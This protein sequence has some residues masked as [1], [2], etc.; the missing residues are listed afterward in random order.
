MASSSRHEAR[1]IVQPRVATDCEALT[2]GSQKVIKEETLT[3]NFCPKN[4][5]IQSLVGESSSN[6]A[7][8]GNRGPN[9]VPEASQMDT[10]KLMKRM[11]SNREASR[12]SRLRKKQ[13][14]EQLERSISFTEMDLAMISPQIAYYQ[15]CNKR[16]EMK[17]NEMR[18]RLVAAELDRAYEDGNM[19]FLPIHIPF[20][21][22][23]TLIANRESA[24]R[25]W[26]RQKEHTAQ[27][28]IKR[29][30]L[31]IKLSNMYQLRTY[32][33]NEHRRLLMENNQLRKSLAAVEFEKDKRLV[34]ENILFRERSAAFEFDKA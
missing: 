26:L 28:E 3:E 14:V 31:Q 29:E 5:D 13:H 10:E 15:N 12:R 16:L 34:M 24:R 6:I 4:Q 22:P 20:F 30:L 33:E 7:Q 25:S 27:L 8:A 11:E 1:P 21:S 19:N 23:Y 32:C 17:N 9:P 18:K 2:V